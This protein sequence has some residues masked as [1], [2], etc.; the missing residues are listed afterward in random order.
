MA[1]VEVGAEGGEDAGLGGGR[2]AWNAELEG[3]SV[4]EASDSSLSGGI[5]GEDEADMSS[6]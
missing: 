4:G 6:G 5:R 3:E 1:W 2:V